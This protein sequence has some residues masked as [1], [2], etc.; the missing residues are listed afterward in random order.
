MSRQ[1]GGQ[2]PQVGQC[3]G[4]GRRGKR[5]HY[6]PGEPQAA[7]RGIVQPH[8]HSVE[9]QQVL[10]LLAAAGLGGGVSGWSEGPGTASCTPNPRPPC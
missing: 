9:G 10:V 1:S 4:E 3:G 5:S 7:D 8:D 2:D 6:L